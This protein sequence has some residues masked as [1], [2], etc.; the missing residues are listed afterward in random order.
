MSLM[1]LAALS[2]LSVVASLLPAAVSENGLTASERA[3]ASAFGVNFAVS[4]ASGVSMTIAGDERVRRVVDEFNEGAKCSESAPSTAPPALAR[5]PRR[6]DVG[7]SPLATNNF[8]P[9]R[10]P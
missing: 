6:P 9:T 7:L 1:I 3:A 2:Y 4:L 8:S 5:S 10:A